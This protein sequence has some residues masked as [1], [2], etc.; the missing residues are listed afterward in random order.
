MVNLKHLRIVGLNNEVDV[1]I[2][3]QDNRLILV[4]DNGQGKSTIVNLLYFFLTRQWRRMSQYS[5]SRFSLNINGTE[6]E[7]AKP[8]LLGFLE[9]E[10]DAFARRNYSSR[11]SFIM[12]RMIVE[13]GPLSLEDLN[14]PA[15]YRD[16]VRKYGL[17]A[18]SLGELRQF[19][20]HRNL[21]GIRKIPQIAEHIAREL[22]QTTILFLPTYRRIEQELEYIVPSLSRR[23]KDYQAPES[24]PTNQ[25]EESAL[26][27]EFARFGM[28]DVEELLKA[29][30]SSLR[31]RARTRL[32]NLLGTYLRDIIN[33][34]YAEIDRGVLSTLDPEAVA[35]IINRVEDSIL[36]SEEKGIL[37]AKVRDLKQEKANPQTRLSNRDKMVLHFLGRLIDSAEIQ[38][39]EEQELRGFAVACN[40]YLLNKEVR[41]D[42]QSLELAVISTTQAGSPVIN[43]RLLSSGEKQVI[44]LFAHIFLSE[45]N[46]LLVIIDEPELS[47]SV[48]WQKKFLPDI[49]SSE[50]CRGVIAVT[51]SPYIFENELDPYARSIAESIISVDK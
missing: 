12:R 10:D 6:L 47:L 46:N 11:V 27:V 40:N 14:D 41:F 1:S 28:T 4:G 42:E 45:Q 18:A 31:D 44:S 48:E 51:H 8:D 16:L 30:T 5:F 39:G 26:F 32:N 25:Q 15:K 23:L 35:R 37:V 2:P 7:L 50:K 9:L 3:I 36:S 34:R 20:E 19:L 43:W 49:L 17:T 22:G 21:T 13:Q 24:S 38:R 33:E 29:R